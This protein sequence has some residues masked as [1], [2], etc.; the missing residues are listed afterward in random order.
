MAVWLCRRL[1]GNELRGDPFTSVEEGSRRTGDSRVALGV[2]SRGPRRFRGRDPALSA[3]GPLVTAEPAPH[4]VGVGA[5]SREPVARL[6]KRVLEGGW[7]GRLSWER[8]RAVRRLRGGRKDRDGPM[9][10]SASALAIQHNRCTWA[11]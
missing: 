5:A 1:R 3:S 9:D 4:W 10:L 2:G 7:G 8:D 6:L 11:R